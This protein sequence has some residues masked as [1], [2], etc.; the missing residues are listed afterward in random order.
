MRLPMYLGKNAL[1]WDLTMQNNPSGGQVDRD[2][3]SR[4]TSTAGS[5]GR[6]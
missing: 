1:L 6:A 4:T 2:Y 3:V 5:L